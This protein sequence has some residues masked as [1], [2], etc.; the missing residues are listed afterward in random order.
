MQK[1]EHSNNKKSETIKYYE[2]DRE[3]D[4]MLIA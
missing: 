4:G 1:H 2:T 3:T